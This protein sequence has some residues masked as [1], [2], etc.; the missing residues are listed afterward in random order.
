[1]KHD[2]RIQMAKILIVDDSI[3]NI[4]LLSRILV[5]A[6]FS[7]ISSTLKSEEVCDLYAVNNYDLI[8][9]D[10][11]MPCLD[12]FQIMQGLKSINSGGSIP[13]FVLSAQPNHEQPSFKA[14]ARD[15]ISKPFKLAD[16]V[17]R[18]KIMLGEILGEQQLLKIA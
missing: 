7:H 18:I 3:V 12:G 13:V 8:L 17:E 6:G 15:F 10:I 1:M 16:L 4:T 11:Q 2:D 9:L 5:S 14:G